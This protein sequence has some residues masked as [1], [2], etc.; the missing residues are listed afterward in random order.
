MRDFEWFPNTVKRSSPSF[1]SKKYW[2]DCSRETQ[3]FGAAMLEIHTQLK[4]NL[5]KL[6]NQSWFQCITKLWIHRLKPGLTFKKKSTPSLSVCLSGSFVCTFISKSVQP[7]ANEFAKLNL[8]IFS[9]VPQ[10]ILKVFLYCCCHIVN[11]PMI[12]SLQV[13]LDQLLLSA[14]LCMDPLW[15]IYICTFWSQLICK[16]CH[17][18]CKAKV[19]KPWHL[20][21]KVIVQM[22]DMCTMWRKFW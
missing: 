17:G 20:L 8:E 12:S 19:M 2:S 13:I 15:W 4:G 21:M 22:N 16:I 10:S 1:L 5:G 6:M 14:A 7:Q 3:N 11:W 9:F 18:Q